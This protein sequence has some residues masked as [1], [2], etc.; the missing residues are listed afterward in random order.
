MILC[1]RSKVPWRACRR[2][3]APFLTPFDTDNFYMFEL[4]AGKQINFWTAVFAPFSPQLWGTIAG[5]VIFH[6]LAISILTNKKHRKKSRKSVLMSPMQRILKVHVA[7]V[8]ADLYNSVLGFVSGGVQDADSD[9]GIGKK[10][11]S[12]GYGFFVLVVLA[13][14][15][16]RCARASVHVCL[17]RSGI[18]GKFRFESCCARLRPSVLD[19][20]GG[21]TSRKFRPDGSC[22]RRHGELM[23]LPY[24]PEHGC[25]PGGH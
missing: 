20:G 9:D 17:S 22:E 23:L 13:A 24:C 4:T 25:G 2:Q 6:G 19:T 18:A 3:L 8:V 7:E 5:L 11:L 14:C 16:S 10:L 12:I 21:V 15:K 1:S